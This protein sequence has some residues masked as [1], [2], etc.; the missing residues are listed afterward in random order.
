MRRFIVSNNTG[1]KEKTVKA[2]RTGCLR[3][4]Q[5]QT[6]KTHTG[7]MVAEENRAN[8]LKPKSIS[9]KIP[10]SDEDKVSIFRN[11]YRNSKALSHAFLYN[12]TCQ[13]NENKLEIVLKKKKM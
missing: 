7:D 8:T 6:G 4:D 9:A 11:V 2:P 3:S 1:N 10:I 12:R 5:N 13:L